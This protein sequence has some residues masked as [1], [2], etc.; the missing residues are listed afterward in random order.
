MT[1]RHRFVHALAVSGLLLGAASLSGQAPAAVQPPPTKIAVFVSHSGQDEVGLV[2]LEKIKEALNR[3]PST[4]YTAASDD[5]DVVLYVSTL[6]PDADKPA[7]VTTAGW[8]L[9]LVNEAVKMYLGSGLR[10]CDRDRAQKTADELVARVDA[11]LKGRQVQLPSS[12]EWRRYMADWTAEVE[13][14]A[15]TIPEDACG[16]KARTAFREQMSTYLRLSNVA[17]LRLNVRDVIGSV[18]AN[19]T[20]EGEFARKLQGQATSLAQC[21]AELAALK[22]APIKK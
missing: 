2:L 3:S 20:T 15:E 9:V 8:S 5:A 16:M 11:L 18:V 21:Q 10:L 1:T 12:S 6:N 22:K 17:G 7:V 14:T 4:S 13:K 19:Y